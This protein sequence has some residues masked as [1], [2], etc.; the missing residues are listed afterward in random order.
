MAS[1][2]T[3][4]NFKK[5]IFK[6]SPVLATKLIYSHKFK[7][8]LNLKEPIDFNE[9]IQWLKLFWQDK[10]IVTCA[11][12][13]KVRDF[14]K[15]RVGEEFLIPLISEFDSTNHIEWDIL[16]ESF[17]IKTNNSSGTNIVVKDKK[18]IDIEKYTKKIDNWLDQDFSLHTFE[19]QY[20][21]MKP[22]IIIEKLLGKGE[23]LLDYRFFCFNGK[24]IF[25]Y[26]SIDG[27]YD[28]NGYSNKKVRKIYLDFEW[29]VLD[30]GND[31]LA[32]ISLEDI[33]NR[34]DNL[35]EMIEVS[36]KLSE[37]FPFVRVDLYNVNGKIY[38]GEMTFTPSGGLA[39]YYNKETLIKLGNLIQLPSEKKRGFKY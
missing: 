15:D 32:K 2:N 17:I 10:N 11:D 1:F 31:K 25:L 3:K 20:K 18:S 4:R 9:K 13:F 21:F 37:G 6:F 22:K 5:T 35:N 28:S 8:K 29:N 23:P 24:P 7:T 34:P 30:Y 38:F 26:L 19:P 27:D 16:P 14:V 33:P 39:D 36:K 12:K